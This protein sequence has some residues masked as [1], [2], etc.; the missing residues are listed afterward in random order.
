MFSETNSKGGCG[1]KDYGTF[2]ELLLSFVLFIFLSLLPDYTYGQGLIPPGGSEK[3]GTKTVG[4]LLPLSGEYELI[5][6]K[7]LKGI[8]T[9]VGVFQSDSDFQIAVMDYNSRSPERNRRALEEIVAKD[10]ASA[11]IGPILSSSIREI[12]ESIKS[13][14]IP[15]VVFPLSEGI[16]DGNPYLIKFSYSLEKQALVLANYAVQDAKIKTLGIL[17]PKTGLGE[18]SKEAFIKSVREYAGNIIYIGSYDPGS[19]NISGETEWIKSRHPDAV[20]IPDGATHSAQLIKKLRREDSLGDLIFLGPNTWNSQTF[21]KAVGTGTEGVVFTDF[22]FPG[23]ERWIDFNA[24]FRAAFGEE[25]GFLEYQVYEAT[26]LILQILKAPIQKRED[27]K[28]RLL[29]F[30]NPLFDIKE[31]VDGSLTISPKP[32]ILTLSEGEVVRVK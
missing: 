28:E 26:S 25:P 11:V 23:S 32:L 20:F 9:A 19:L 7:A 29:S 12:S 4:C 24:K 10:G 21:L 5:G 6:K 17:Y 30:N 3:I 1:G 22:F 31:N 14:R 2:L 27:I 15:T 13:L 18:L 16:S 8:L